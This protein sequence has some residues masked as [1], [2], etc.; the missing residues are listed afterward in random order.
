MIVYKT[1]NIF[2]E[3][4]EAIV[5]T[6]NCVGVMGKGLALEFKKRF[7]ENFKQYVAACNRSML[8]PGRM[9][10]H[11]SFST[12]GHRYIINFPTKKHWRDPSRIEYIE[13]G[14]HDLTDVI[15]VFNIE[16]IAIPALGCGLGGLD[17]SR[18]RKLI[19]T[20]LSPLINVSIVV[21]EPLNVN[22]TISE[23]ARS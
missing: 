7:P 19:D 6:V 3:N 1:G 9:F 5:N 22:T 10:T 17:W 15:S 20:I 14:L 16:S 23:G 12:E 21:F 13:S 4:T 11:N 8:R 18:V 2:D